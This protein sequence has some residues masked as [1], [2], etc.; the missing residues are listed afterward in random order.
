MP[1]PTYIKLTKL[2]PCK[3]EVT[4]RCNVLAICREIPSSWP[5]FLPLTRVWSEHP[6]CR[7]IWAQV[8]SGVGVWCGSPQLPH[9]TLQC[10]TSMWICFLILGVCLLFG[11]LI[12]VGLQ[13]CSSPPISHPSLSLP[14]HTP[15]PPP[16]IYKSTCNVHILIMFS[17]RAKH[18]HIV[19]IMC[20]NIV[21]VFKTFCS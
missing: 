3:L 6:Q 12:F 9:V 5:R 10:S 17:A 1:R 18:V 11:F 20:P 13:N 7:G 2:S 14:A 4:Y 8:W 21:L 19:P 15:P 16:L